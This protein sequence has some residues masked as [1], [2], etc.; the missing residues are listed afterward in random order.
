MHINA[1]MKFLAGKNY[2]LFLCIG[3]I[4][5]DANEVGFDSKEIR[6]INR[7]IE[8]FGITQEELSSATNV[9]Q[10]QISRILS[11]QI[12]RESKSYKKIC[13]YVLSRQ[14]FPTIEDVCRNRELIHAL[15]SIW[16]GSDAQAK[17]LAGVIKSLGSLTDAPIW[18]I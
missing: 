8:L 17:K 3:D 6:H 12:K 2:L 18:R 13:E 4:M 10:S 15:A 1:N 11:G 9:S 5:S 7:L 14:K 16:D